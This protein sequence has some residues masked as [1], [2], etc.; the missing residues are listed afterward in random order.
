MS[1]QRAVLLDAAAAVQRAATALDR[2]D[3]MSASGAGSR[4]R[5]AVRSAQPL[6]PKAARATGASTAR[7]RAALAELERRRALLPAGTAAGTAL[8][9]VVAAGREEAGA[10]ERF[11]A[12][13]ERVWPVYARLAA[14]T[15]LWSTRSVSGWYRSQREGAAAYAVLV[16]GYRRQLEGA[17]AR[18]GRAADDLA[19]WTGRQRAALAEANRRLA[20][21]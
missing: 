19:R 14:D 13:A 8:T 1:S 2:A 11:L 7:Y 10:F 20:A 4:A 5:A 6:V 9:D 3:E 15:D 12:A 17:R 16:D 21:Q 18:L